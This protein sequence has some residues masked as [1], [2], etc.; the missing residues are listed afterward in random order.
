MNKPND[1]THIC[2]RSN[3]LYKEV[4][5]KVYVWSS[6]GKWVESI[7]SPLAGHGIIQPLQLADL[8][9]NKLEV[10]DD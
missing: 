4:D 5:G 6:N 10:G 7:G 3:L 1:A 8:W 9:L 2:S